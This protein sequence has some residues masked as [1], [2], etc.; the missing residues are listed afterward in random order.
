MINSWM[1]NMSENPHK[2]LRFSTSNESSLGSWYS[3]SFG[4]IENGGDVFTEN[5][6]VES[7]I[8]GDSPMGET[9]AAARRQRYL[10]AHRRSFRYSLHYIDDTPDSQADNFSLVLSPSAVGRLV[11]GEA[12]PKP[13]AG[14]EGA[15]T[16]RRAQLSMESR[17]KCQIRS[18]FSGQLVKYYV[19]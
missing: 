13:K 7:E 6:P 9:Q 1:R 5:G 3:S 15:I 14:Q 19:E 2:S 18:N 11:A 8:R 16:V 4:S 17:E 12:Q 10:R